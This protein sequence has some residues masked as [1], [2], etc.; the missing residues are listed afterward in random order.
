M[1]TPL[2]VWYAIPSA[3]AANCAE[4]LPEWR[5][6]GYKIA[7]L[8]D[9]DKRFDACADLIVAPFETYPG[10][11]KAINYLIREVVPAG[12]PIVVT[13]GDDMFPDMA[14]TAQ[15][16]AAQFIARFPD[17]FGV[18]QPMG[19][20]YGNTVNICG[21]PWIGRA[22]ARRIYGGR[23]AYCRAY[24]QLYEDQELHD[25]ADGLGV[26]WKRPDLAQF[27]K[28]WQRES[29]SAE[30]PVY[31]RESLKRENESKNLYESRRSA[32]FPGHEPLRAPIIEAKLP[33]RRNPV[34]LSILVPSLPSRFEK[35]LKPLLAKLQQQT[36]HRADVEVLTFSDN[37]MRSVGLKRDALVQMA[38]GEFCAFV[39]DD[40]DVSSDYVES[41]VACIAA[42]PHA[43]VVTFKQISRINDGNPYVV[44]FGLHHENE[45]AEQ[46]G[47][48]RWKDIKRRPYHVCAFRTELAKRQRFPDASYGE[49][50]HWAKRVLMDV[51]A[52]AKIDKVLHYYFYRDTVTEAALVFPTAVSAA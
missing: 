37:K 14:H 19:D 29:A 35:L 47:A 48:G 4:V 18:M 46:D 30:A 41:I 16:L 43:D 27:H 1:T 11:G 26:L 25:V 28:H 9:R 33:A 24:F 44:D 52:E 5:A 21:S 15:E 13:G 50:W 23:G 2:E 12:A 20:R 31:L 36:A 38:R 51:R 42:N 39:D 32:G 34:A 17:T 40:D 22:F 7:L 49:D 3:N 6:R 10:Y 45:P 8:Q